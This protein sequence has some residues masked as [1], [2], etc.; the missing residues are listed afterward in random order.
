[1]PWIVLPTFNEADNLE[2]IVGAVR[3]AMPAARILVVDDD[4]PD[5]TGAI[6]DRLAAADP[7]VQVLHRPAKEGL[8]RAYVAGF[9]HALGRGA[10]FVFEMDA[11][12]SHAPADLPRLLAAA[13][14]GA[15]LALGSRYVPG[16]GVEN[17]HPVR[18]LVSRAGC[19]YARRVLG[20]AVHDLT[21]GLKCFRADTLRRIDYA[22]VRSQGYAFQVELTYRTLLA[23]LRVVELPIV[24]RERREGQSKM[25]W[26]I[27]AEAAFMVPRLRADHRGSEV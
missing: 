5:G 10:E 24:F 26:R 3:T 8:G 17:W 14:G 20:V 19:E 12:F 27:A 11:D 16:G 23:G 25:T 15:D 2:G 7:A 1:M 22:S 6:A 18:R 9:E 21:G 13:R 4:S